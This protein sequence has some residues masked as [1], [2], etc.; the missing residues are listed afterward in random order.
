MNGLPTRTN[1]MVEK[2]DLVEVTLPPEPSNPHVGLS[3]VPIDVRYEDADY[4]IVNKPPFLP[5]VQS[6]ANQKDTLVNRVKNYYVKIIMKA[7]LSMW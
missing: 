3:D 1:A 2:G 4:L 5:T 7:E 6:A